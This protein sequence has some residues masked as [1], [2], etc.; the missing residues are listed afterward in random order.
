MFRINLPNLH[1][2]HLG[3]LITAMLAGTVAARPDRRHLHRGP[4]RHA[5]PLAGNRHRLGQLAVRRDIA[6]DLAHPNGPVGEPRTAA[7]PGFGWSTTPAA[8]PPIVFWRPDLTGL[9]LQSSLRQGPCA[10][11]MSSIG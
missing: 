2:D 10:V 5:R 4:S 9:R 11:K 6:G 7:S 3:D 1:R 8:N